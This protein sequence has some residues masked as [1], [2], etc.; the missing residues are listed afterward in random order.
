MNISNTTQVKQYSVPPMPQDNSIPTKTYELNW[1]AN[2]NFFFS[3]FI[4]YGFATP[5]S[6]GVSGNEVQAAYNLSPSPDESIRTISLAHP[7][8]H[9]PQTSNEFTV[10]QYPYEFTFNDIGFPMA[11]GGSKIPLYWGRKI[12][13]YGKAGTIRFDSIGYMLFFNELAKD[14]EDID[15]HYTI[16][17]LPI[18]SDRDA[19]GGKK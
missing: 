12:N 7:R 19:N 4:A 9:G 15:F 18:V 11:E 8:M 13:I 6:F 16:Q 10:T 5:A 1:R 3:L 17:E 14:L 2:D